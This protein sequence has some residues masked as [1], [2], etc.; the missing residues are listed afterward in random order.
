VQ[1]AYPRTYGSYLLL[2]PLG[3]GGMSEVELARR[4][5]DETRYVRFVVI[6][7]IHQRHT[8]DPGFVRMFQ[9]EARINAE[10]HHENIAQVFD[11]G[12]VGDEWYL[13]MEYVP[14]MDLRGVIKRCD[15]REER[16][17]LRV[18]M[19]VVHDVLRALAYAHTRVDT[20]G[21][22]MRI[23]HR[24]VNPRNVMVSVRGEVKLIDFGVAKADTRSEQT[25][26]EVIKG[27]FAYM[28]PEQIESTT[29]VDGRADLYAV[30]LMLQEL[31]VGEHPFAG[32]REIQIVHRVLSGNI[33]IMP[34]IPG[35]PD[36][37]RLRRIVARALATRAE[38]R[39]ADAE[40]FRRDIEAVAVPL[41]G[42]PS[43]AEVAEFVRGLDP[44]RSEGISERLQAWRDFDSPQ[45]DV[46]PPPPPAESSISEPSHSASVSIVQ[47][48]EAASVANAEPQSGWVGADSMVAAAPPQGRP[49]PRN[50]LAWAL[51]GG[52]IMAAVVA[53]I[54]LAALVL[55]L[56]TGTTRAPDPPADDGP[57]VGRDEAPSEPGDTTKAAGTPDKSPTPAATEAAPAT[58]NG[59]LATT[60]SKSTTTSKARKAAPSAAAPAHATNDETTTAKATAEPSGSGGGTAAPKTAEPDPVKPV[61]EAAPEAAPA[62]TPEGAPAATTDMG[63]LFITSK[64][65]K[66]YEVRVNGQLIGHT[67][68]GQKR[69]PV[70]EAV[71]EVTDAAS[72]RS[73]QKTVTVKK[74]KP[75]HF[76]GGP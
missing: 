55:L 38:D 68:V 20:Y 26:G 18:A 49:R 69:W 63:F 4:A 19:K 62:P 61:V 7:R 41:G 71:I 40:A 53:A 25:V 8:T 3:Q 57:H 45:V 36:P 70:G 28:A 31:L 2:E 64:P 14:G 52:G 46:P 34:D 16:L 58:T 15:A 1:P 50:R 76:V 13:A 12:H 24:D 22:P 17:P 51:A 6:K 44:D 30:G 9:D 5:V 42:L 59:R 10:L 47:P 11:F 35:H 23:V 67:P 73:W 54:G 65:T 75:V 21:Q 48:Q 43:G 39:Y 32:L 27:K 37:D 56:P 74:G 72:G 66:G 60:G 29:G 33:A